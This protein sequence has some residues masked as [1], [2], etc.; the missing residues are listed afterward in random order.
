MFYIFTHYTI[1]RV[2]KQSQPKQLLSSKVVYCMLR[3]QGA[4]HVNTYHK[5]KKK[6]GA[7]FGKP[8]CMEKKV[9]IVS[10]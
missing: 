6:I 8:S 3:S 7:I 10:L 1:I 4:S 2:Y 9:S 5:K